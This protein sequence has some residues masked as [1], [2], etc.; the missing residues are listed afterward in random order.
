MI[1]CGKNLLRGMKVMSLILAGLIALAV[2]EALAAESVSSKPNILV[3][4]SDDQG[5]ADYGFVSHKDEVKTPHL[6]ALARDGTFFPNTLATCPVCSPSRSGIMTGRYPQRGGD[7]WFTMEAARSGIPAEA[8]TTAEYLREAGY[9]TGYIGKVHYDGARPVPG[10]RTFPTEHGFS[11]FFGAT[12]GGTIHYLLHSGKVI[13]EKGKEYAAKNFIAP[14][15]LNDEPQRNLDGFTTDLFADDAVKFIKE[16]AGKQPFYLHVAWNAV[17]TFC[18]Q[19]PPEEAKRRGFELDEEGNAIA[20][21]RSLY[22]AQL[23][24]LDGGVG[25]ILD[26]LKQSG[27]LDNTLILYT[28]DNG[29]TSGSRNWPLT[30]GKYHLYEGGVR[31]PII[32][33]F[34]GR[35]TA[36]A[37]SDAHVSHLDLLPTILEAAGVSPKPGT[38][39][40]TILFSSAAQ[41]EASAKRTLHHDTGFQWSVHQG[42]WKLLVTS[43][44]NF[45]TN[46]EK[47]YNIKF[48]RGVNLFDLS[49]DPGE[50]TNL[51]AAHPEIVTSLTR[52]HDNWRQG[53]HPP[54]ALAATSEGH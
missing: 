11:H 44:E 13:N 6:D 41:P 33:R 27:Q 49:S 10:L 31:C 50:K 29:G 19:L 47:K 5:Y 51:A 32:A 18:K 20:P 45:A 54:A 43:D 26:A 24:L 12:T 46:L 53:C 42:D 35:F 39:D 14:L 16:H 30:G 40:G 52:L 21:L 17:H 15:W 36:G 28:T 23:E 37:R 22:L 25:R 4:L 38:L 2:D 1:I 34:P 9:V 7:Y 3:L 48:A 8:K